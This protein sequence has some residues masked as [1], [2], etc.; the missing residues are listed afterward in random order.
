MESTLSSCFLAYYVFPLK[1]PFYTRKGLYPG[2]RDCTLAES[3][4]YLLESTFPS[5]WATISSH[6][7]CSFCLDFF[8]PEWV[9]L[10]CRWSK[11]GDINRDGW[12]ISGTIVLLLTLNSKAAACWGSSGYFSSQD[13]ERGLLCPVLTNTQ[14]PP[15]HTRSFQRSAAALPGSAEPVKVHRLHLVKTYLPCTLCS[16]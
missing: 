5:S 6:F 9:H 15:K 12:N 7:P 4:L 16:D 1:V 11:A 2:K 8:T 10:L 3:T 14:Q 13:K